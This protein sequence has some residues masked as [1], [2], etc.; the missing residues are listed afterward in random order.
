M[1]ASLKLAQ[2]FPDYQ[3][4]FV[5]TSLG[6]A[7]A[8][9]AAV[10]FNVRFG[11]GDRISLYTF[12]QPRVGDS[13]WARYVNGLPFSS[14]MYR[15]SRRGDPVPHLPPMFLGYEHSLQMYSI[16]DNG[17]YI[18]CGLEPGMGED[19]FDPGDKEDCQ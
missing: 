4:I 3:I 18:K 7:L 5:G 6:G 19:Y 1:T 14:R 15:I 10:D 9:L 17:D 12:G 11:Y 2:Q 16:L 8:T 13:N